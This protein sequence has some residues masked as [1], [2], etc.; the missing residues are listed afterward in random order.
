MTGIRFVGGS[1]RCAGC[2]CDW[3]ALVWCCGFAKVRVHDSS[4]CVH[5]L[6]SVCGVLV[7]MLVAVP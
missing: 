7:V 4:L 6:V 2:V 3:S 5:L 1:D